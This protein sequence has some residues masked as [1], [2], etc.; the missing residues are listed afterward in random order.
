M[1]KEKPT[2]T[3]PEDQDIDEA[4]I[5]EFAAALE[6]EEEGA[7]TADADSPVK[8]E[9]PVR[10]VNPLPA[11]K[12]ITVNP[13]RT[14]RTLKIKKIPISDAADQ[15][16]N[17]WKDRPQKK[18]APP[19]MRELKKSS[20]RH[21]PWNWTIGILVVLAGTSI[22]G[23][24]FFNRADRFSGTRVQVQVIPTAEVASGSDVTVNIRYQ[25]QEPVDLVQTELTIEY[26]D[27]FTYRSADQNPTNEFHNAFSLGTIKS[28]RAGEFK[29]IG[30]MIGSIN[31]ERVFKATLTY[32]TANFN[33]DFQETAEG[34]SKITSS[35]LAVKIEGPTEAA[36]GATVSWTVS[37]ENTSD[38]TVDKIQIE[39]DYPD[40]VTI[41]KTDPAA[42][43]RNA[44]WQIDDLAKQAKGKITLTAL[45]NGAIGDTLP[46]VVRAGLVTATN[47]VDLQDEQSLLVI[48]IKTGVSLTGSVNG[49]TDGGVILPGDQLNYSLRVANDSDTEVSDLT[50]TATMSGAALDLVDVPTDTN[51]YLKDKI[52]TWTKKEVPGLALLKPNQDLVIRWTFNTKKALTVTSD[53]D[54]NQKI[55]ASVAAAST[56]LVGTVAPTDIVTKLTTVMALKAEGR[57][58]DDQGKAYGT[59]PIPPKVGQ[60]TSYRITWTITSTTNQV[61][62]LRVTTTLPISV[63]WTGQNIGRDAGDIAFDVTS[64][65]VTWS[66]NRV[67]AGT[68][69]RLPALTAYFEVS[70]TPTADQVGS[71]AVLTD[72]SVAQATDSYTTTA[73]KVTQSSITSDVPN[74][75]TAGGEGTIVA[76]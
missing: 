11:T 75:P 58:A 24:F 7:K 35:I 26:P 14:G 10:P 19:E 65:T 57:Y 39:A 27:G 22:A 67:P 46:I 3:A 29:I 45:V 68:G 60:T 12:K 8:P 2:P 36:P 49:A 70:I 48:L 47:T 73:L 63:F 52:L 54:L 74:D 64:R 50:I 37:Y 1:A 33:S 23:F 66:I 6:T 42:L 25:N 43:E 30:T 40:G 31:T 76:Q 71:L 62:G 51:K 53:A 28:G 18:S 41:T 59:G 20:G 56:S 55:I 69:T 16:E 17:V 4:E 13:G 32:R 9:P 44:L 15:L 72:Q 61:D 5:A 21:F 34:T 38:R